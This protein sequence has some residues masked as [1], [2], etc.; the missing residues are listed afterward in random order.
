MNDVDV[1]GYLKSV[2]PVEL[3]TAW[4][5]ETYKA[6]AIAARTY[7]I[8]ESKTAGTQAILGRLLR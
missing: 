8:Y 7:A 3:Y 5:E 4:E 2:I 6:Q 1:D